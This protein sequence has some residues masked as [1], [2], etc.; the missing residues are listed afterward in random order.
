ME[1]PDR[2]QEK[3]ILIRIQ[4]NMHYLI[5]TGKILDNNCLYSVSLLSTKAGLSRDKR[6]IKKTG[7][8]KEN[9]DNIGLGYLLLFF[10]YNTIVADLDLIDEE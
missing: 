6:Q 7:K 2:H 9:C 1:D 3:N 10:I 4:I 5:I 8:V